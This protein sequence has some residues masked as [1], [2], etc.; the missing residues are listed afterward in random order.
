M[1]GEKQSPYHDEMIRNARRPF[2][3]FVAPGLILFMSS[4]ETL[5]EEYQRLC[6]EWNDLTFT[7]MTSRKEKEI[8]ILLDRIHKLEGMGYN[9][10]ELNLYDFDR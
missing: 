8:R 7:I 3:E 6:K 4:N 1:S 5:N 10:I 2:T 9:Y